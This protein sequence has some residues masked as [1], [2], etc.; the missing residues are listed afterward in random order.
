M[1]EAVFVRDFS[2]MSEARF[3]G[4]VNANHTQAKFLKGWLNRVH[5]LLTL[6]NIPDA[7]AAQK[8]VKLAMNSGG[9]KLVRFAHLDLLGE[10][11]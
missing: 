1:V 4:I 7:P 8:F 6:A 3:R 11:A 5:R 10:V 9:E 2:T